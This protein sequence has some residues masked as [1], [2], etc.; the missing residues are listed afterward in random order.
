MGSKEIYIKGWR[1]SN[2]RDVVM[3]YL[4][5]LLFF[6][7][8]K[9]VYKCIDIVVLGELLENIKVLAKVRLLLVIF[10]EV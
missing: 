3:R 2:L 1:G 10:D 8:W 4:V 6:L 7:I 5:K 9:V